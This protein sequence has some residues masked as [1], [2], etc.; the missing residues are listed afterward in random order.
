MKL[1][2]KMNHI[3]QH[4]GMLHN[5]QGEVNTGK[6]T[7]LASPK[8]QTDLLIGIGKKGYPFTIDFWENWR[9]NFD[10][11]LQCVG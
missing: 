10:L 7:G 4:G 6:K 11:D 9:W 1:P 2:D 5:L 3:G 8:K